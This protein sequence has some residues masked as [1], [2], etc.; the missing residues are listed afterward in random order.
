M[1]YQ[2]QQQPGCGGCLLLLLLF[3][4]LTGGFSGL[5]NFLGTLIYIGLA[6]I[7]IFTGLFWGFSYWIRH[8]VSTY[9]ASQTESH[10]RFVWLLVQILINIAKIDGVV[11]KEEISTIQRFF[12]QNLR[13]D[14]TKMYWVKELIKEAVSSTGPM[15]TLLEEFR[16]TFAYEPRLI[17]LE[18]IYQVLYTKS[19]VSDAEL[20]MA[21][22]IA[23]YLQIKEYD[24]RTIEAKY[25]YGSQQQTASPQGAANQAYAVLGLEPGADKETIK[26]AYRKLSMKYHP[27]KVRHLGEEFRVVAEEKMKEI[28]AAYDF[29]KKK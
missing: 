28:N 5:F 9:E 7:L 2:R 18:L 17:L 4:L 14:Q 22:D 8:K 24:K 20:K 15:E 25:K 11:S 6:G 29:F 26:R 13:Y 27:D 23:D 12:Q 1:Q 19:R 3:S 21:R 10:N 16:N